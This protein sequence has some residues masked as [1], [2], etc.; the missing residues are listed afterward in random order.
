M[1][2]VW[3]LLNFLGAYLAFERLKLRLDVSAWIWVDLRDESPP[4][5]CLRL[6]VIYAARC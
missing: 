6:L 3:A 2:I 5:P 4:L 1:V